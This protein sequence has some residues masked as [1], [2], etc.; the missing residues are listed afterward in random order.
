M[1]DESLVMM[2]AMRDQRRGEIYGKGKRWVGRRPCH[3]YQL[4]TYIYTPAEVSSSRKMV[5]F[6][7]WDMKDEVAVAFYKLQSGNSEVLR[8][9]PNILGATT[10]WPG[11]IRAM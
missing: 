7:H 5:C 2:M 6:R 10:A 1:L 4:P 8:I 9:I 11:R 3:A